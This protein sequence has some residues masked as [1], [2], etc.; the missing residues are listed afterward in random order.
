MTTM[1]TRNIMMY[2]LGALIILAFFGLLGLLVLYPVPEKNNQ[3]LTIAVGALITSF[4]MVVGYFYGSSKGSADKNELLN[5]T[6]T[7]N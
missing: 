6:K 3:V 1:K 7:G 2:V 4:S 5:G